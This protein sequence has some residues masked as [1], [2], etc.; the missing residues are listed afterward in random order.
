MEPMLPIAAAS[1]NGVIPSLLQW[2][3]S[4]PQDIV[5]LHFAVPH[6][7]Q[8]LRFFDLTRT[9]WL[10]I[11]PRPES[12]ISRIMSATP[13]ARQARSQYRLDRPCRW[14]AKP[15]FPKGLPLKPLLSEDD[16]NACIKAVTPLLSSRSIDALPFKSKIATP[17]WS[18]F[19]DAG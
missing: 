12:M 8:S 13:L 7:V 19:H 16:V 11:S 9:V 5:R 6:V 2:S 4:A 10:S 3:I 15:E 1:I 14:Y 18:C 17:V